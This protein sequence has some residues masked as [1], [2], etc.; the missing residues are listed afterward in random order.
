MIINT[1]TIN[2]DITPSLTSITNIMTVIIPWEMMKETSSER[3]PMQFSSIKIMSVARTELI[4]PMLPS[5]KYPIGSFL[6]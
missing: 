1:A 4:L 6:R 5:V 3:T 2:S